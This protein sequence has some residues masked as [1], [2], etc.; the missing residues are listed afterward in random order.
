MFLVACFR[1]G[2]ANFFDVTND[3]TAVTD[4]VNVKQMTQNMFILGIIFWGNLVDNSTNP[5]FILITCE[6]VIALSY[7]SY[8]SALFLLHNDLDKSLVLNLI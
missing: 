1:I 6:A 8:A 7:L 4:E 3:Q 5:R 2:L